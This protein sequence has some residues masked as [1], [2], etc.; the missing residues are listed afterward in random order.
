MRNAIAHFN[1]EF[2]ADH[3]QTINGLRLW[4]CRNG[5][6]GQKTW[7]AALTIGELR[8]I[9]MRFID[10]IEGRQRRATKG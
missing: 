2:Q 7:E 4:N 10:L 9:T 3:Q 8:E 5:R 1:V 6:S